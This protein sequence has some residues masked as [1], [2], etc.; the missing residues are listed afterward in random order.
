MRERGG[1][2]VSASL[3]FSGVRLGLDDS[4]SDWDSGEGERRRFFDLDGLVAA[5]T[6]CCN[7]SA[8]F[9]RSAGLSLAYFSKITLNLNGLEFCFRGLF[10]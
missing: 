8:H 4:S 1:L 2:R 3:R 7:S 6:A 10:V 5:V 9:H